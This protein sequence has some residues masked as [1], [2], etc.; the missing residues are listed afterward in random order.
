MSDMAPRS[1]WWQASDGKWYP[2]DLQPGHLPPPPI[3]V[4]PPSLSPTAPEAPAIYR[5]PTAP[6]KPKRQVKWARVLVAAALFIAI[7]TYLSHDSPPSS[8]SASAPPLS[9]I[10]PAQS[11]MATNNGTF[12]TLG[13]DML[14]LGQ[15]AS[16]TNPDASTVSND[17]RALSNDVVTAQ[18]LP[19]IPDPTAQGQWSSMLTNMASAGNDCTEGIAQGD[20]GLVAQTATEITTSTGEFAKLKQTVG[21]P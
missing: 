18:A 8:T 6:A 16:A 4:A 19:A 12:T 2:P 3:A 13:Q 7:V 14:T 9:S 5:R 20:S 15:D 21:T 10:T 11:W 17:C 1:G